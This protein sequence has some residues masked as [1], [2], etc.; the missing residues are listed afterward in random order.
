LYASRSFLDLSRAWPL[1]TPGSWQTCF[2]P[3]KMPGTKGSAH[4]EIAPCGLIR[5]RGCS[6]RGVTLSRSPHRT[7]CH[8]GQVRSATRHPSLYLG[9]LNKTYHSDL[10]D[11]GTCASHSNLSQVLFGCKYHDK[12]PCTGTTRIGPFP[13][14]KPNHSYSGEHK[15]RE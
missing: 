7:P 3:E 4:V 6:V 15:A 13:N 11:N 10:S 12:V 2:G 8:S 14:M 5:R 9:D 1:S